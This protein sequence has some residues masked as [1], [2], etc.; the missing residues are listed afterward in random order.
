MD[1]RQSG[2]VRRDIESSRLPGLAGDRLLEVRGDRRA[3]DGGACNPTITG[4]EAEASG[5]LRLRF[6]SHDPFMSCIMVSFRIARIVAVPRRV[7]PAT[8]VFMNGFAFEV[9]DLPFD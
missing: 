9:P 2:G 4:I 6:A 1:R 7:L 5:L 3:G 8:V